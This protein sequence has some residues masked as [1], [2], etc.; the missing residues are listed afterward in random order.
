MRSSPVSHLCHLICFLAFFLF[1]LLFI[2]FTCITPPPPSIFSSFP[3]LFSVSS[4][5]L[6]PSMS[7]RPRA[8]G[9][10]T[11]GTLHE[12]ELLLPLG[13]LA[14]AAGGKPERWS[15]RV[16]VKIPGTWRRRQQWNRGSSKK[17]NSHGG[18][19]CPD[20]AEEPGEVETT[21]SLSGGAHCTGLGPGEHP[22]PVSDRWGR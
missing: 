20:A 13:K 7:A 1:L 9:G 3:I 14:A 6:A 15:D 5:L 12:P 8:L 16:R 21:S 10:A 4:L 19:R 2:F 18:R 17:D 11:R 22:P